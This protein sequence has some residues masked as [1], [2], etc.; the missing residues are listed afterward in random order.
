MSKKLFYVLCLVA[1]ILAI[2]TVPA[3]KLIGYRVIFWMKSTLL[4]CLF[5]LS[6]FI[7]KFKHEFWFVLVTVIVISGSRIISDKVFLGNQMAYFYEA[8]SPG[9]IELYIFKH[10]R[11]RIT[12]GG[13][14]GITDA[15]YG[16]YRLTD[17]IIKV[18]CGCDILE[19]SGHSINLDQRNYI[20]EKE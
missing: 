16:D 17:S 19:L 12:Y 6:S 14:Q 2:L 1:V 7:A 9:F 20:I 8:D 10:N 15:F 5:I 11:C 3:E 4:M 18:N 13:I